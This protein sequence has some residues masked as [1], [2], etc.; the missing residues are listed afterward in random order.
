[1]PVYQRYGDA[2]ARGNVPYRDFALEYPPGAL[3]M[4]A[5]P[6]L[7]EPGNGQDVTTG[8]RHVFETL[9]W[10]CGAAALLAMAVVLHAVGATRRRAWA[11]LVFAALAPLAIGSVL[12]SRY[13]LWPAAL[14]VAALAALV[15]GRFRVGSGVLGAAVTAK[16]Y[17]ALLVPLAV[18]YVWRREGRREALVCLGI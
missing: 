12:L 5:L 17:P 18:T 6:G 2:I 1:T 11:A 16:L 13:D 10:L 15:S 8:F 3:P 9:L 14:V 4:F 7:A